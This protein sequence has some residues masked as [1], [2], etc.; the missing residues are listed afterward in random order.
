MSEFIV[1]PAIDLRGGKVVRLQEGDPERLTAYSDDPAAVAER[2][3]TAGA[4]W[5]HVVNLDG[6]FDQPDSANREALRAILQVGKRYHARVQFGGGLRHL[7]AVEQ[8]LELGVSRVVLGTLA[9]KD[10]ATL[11]EALKR[12]GEDRIAASLD[13]RDGLVRVH[14]WQQTTGVSALQAALILRQAGLHWL[15]FTDIARDGLQTGLNL[16]ATC[17]IARESGLAVVASGGISSAGEVQ[18]V[19]QAN[20]AGVIIGRALYEGAIRLEEVV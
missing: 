12:W 20:L 16:Q 14:G 19:R 8:V 11:T 15:V 3:L 2:W 18:A 1:F 6:A 17:Q 5:L 7:Q 13:A 9:I 10:P 4:R